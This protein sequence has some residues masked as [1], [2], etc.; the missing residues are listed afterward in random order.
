MSAGPE[1]WGSWES[2]RLR[3]QLAGLAVTADERIAWVEEM[4]VVAMA[5]GACP[6][7]RDAWG[8]PLPAD[9]AVRNRP[10]DTGRG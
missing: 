10:S 4:L 9:G 2:T 7:P 6:R 3:G 8:Q 1:D 5:S